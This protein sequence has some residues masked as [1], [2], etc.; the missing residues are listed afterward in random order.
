MHRKCMS[1]VEFSPVL[2]KS[3]VEKAA[4]S[5]VETGCPWVIHYGFPQVVEKMQAKKCD[6]LWQRSKKR[7][8]WRIYTGRTGVL[9]IYP[10][11]C[12]KVL[13]MGNSFPHPCWKCGFLLLT[14]VGAVQFL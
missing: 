11:P 9:F 3:H 6:M 12:L 5:G 13:E 10:H 8:F 2:L 7:T 4:D 1:D 14:A